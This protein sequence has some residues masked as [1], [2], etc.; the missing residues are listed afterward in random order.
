MKFRSHILETGELHR[1]ATREER[2]MLCQGDW[3]FDMQRWE[4]PACPATYPD[5][6]KYGAHNGCAREK[7]FA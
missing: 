4:C 3:S 2:P 1:R 7:D 5:Q 6:C